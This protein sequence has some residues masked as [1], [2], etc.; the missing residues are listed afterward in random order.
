MVVGIASGGGGGLLHFV[1][2][3]VVDGGVC[4][5]RC[6]LEWWWWSLVLVAVVVVVESAAYEVGKYSEEYARAHPAS[7]IE[8]E[9]VHHV[10]KYKQL[11]DINFQA[12]CCLYF[13]VCLNSGGVI[14]GG[15]IVSVVGGGC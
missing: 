5:L 10:R 4:V 12:K 13:R 15:C 7:L 6:R 1:C 2:S 9:M 14:S 8:N 3:G 11:L